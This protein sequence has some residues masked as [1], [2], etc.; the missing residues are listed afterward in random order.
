MVLI[1]FG[2][3]A[4]ILISTATG[5]GPSSTGWFQANF[6]LMALL[7]FLVLRYR[8]ELEQAIVRDPNGPITEDNYRTH[9]MAFFGSRA[10]RAYMKQHMPRFYRYVRLFM[11]VVSGSVLYG[12]LFFFVISL[13]S[14]A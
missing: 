9:A 2:Y 10:E 13:K 1:S 3:L 6:V 5:I 8:K 12:L 7:F 4:L 14:P 11:A